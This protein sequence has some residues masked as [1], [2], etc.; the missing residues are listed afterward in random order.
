MDPLSGRPHFPPPTAEDLEKRKFPSVNPRPRLLPIQVPCFQ[1]MIKPSIDPRSIA[2]ATPETFV[3]GWTISAHIFPAAFPRHITLPGQYDIPPLAG[4]GDKAKKEWKKALFLL[5][6]KIIMEKVAVEGLAGEKG[7]RVLSKARQAPEGIWQSAT[8]I[9]RV[10]TDSNGRGKGATLVVTHSNGFHKEASRLERRIH[11]SDLSSTVMGT[12]LQVSDRSCR[13]G[14]RRI[15][16]RN[17]G[18]GVCGS[19]RHGYA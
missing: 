12:G 1:R 13:T 2:R 7:E 16:R 15:Y 10:D 17:L 19:W 11:N 8:R 4:S 18:S 6:E 9:R 3:Q 14:A 5:A